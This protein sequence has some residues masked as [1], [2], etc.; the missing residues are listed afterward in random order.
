M[1]KFRILSAI[2][3]ICLLMGMVSGCT[4]VDN[5]AVVTIN[6]EAI[7]KDV[8]ALYLYQSSMR[9]ASES[10]VADQA[11]L[12][13]FWE[14]ENNVKTAKD[15]AVKEA[16]VM[17]AKC[18]KAI[19]DGM[20]LTDEEKNA[21]NQQIGSEIS[22]VGSR[23]EFEKQVKESLGTTVDAYTAFIEKMY[24]ASKL[25]SLLMGR[26]IYSKRRRS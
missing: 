7:T 13:A 2:V 20:A 9:L 25:E 21:L 24:L 6:G 26:K 14:D 15:M 23:E 11:G 18:N 17:I 10:G 16:A 5:T 4:V 3:T 12:V 8:F 19:E 22:S 1:K